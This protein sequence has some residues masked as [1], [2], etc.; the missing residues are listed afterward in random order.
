MQKSNPLK[1]TPVQIQKKG[2]E[3][4]TKALGPVGMA[5]FLRQFDL[6][7]GDYTRDWEEWLKDFTV[8]GVVGEID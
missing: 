2:I 3:A 5:R 7:S 4:L 6:G 1:M 8:H